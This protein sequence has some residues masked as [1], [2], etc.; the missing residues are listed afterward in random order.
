MTAAKIAK[1]I[2]GVILIVVGGGMY[3]HPIAS[4]TYSAGSL[5]G[6]PAHR[7][8][9]SANEA[10]FYGAS[11]MIGGVFLLFWAFSTPKSK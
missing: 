5:S 3:L 1:F 4:D 6:I 7:I 8:H 11:M 10:R 2:F 9:L